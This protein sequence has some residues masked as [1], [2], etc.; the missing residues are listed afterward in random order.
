IL[1][2][3]KEELQMSHTA[4]P[5]IMRNRAK[6]VVK[7]IRV[8]MLSAVSLVL[9]STLAYSQAPLL[10]PTVTRAIDLI[11]TYPA[12]VP[13]GTDVVFKRKDSSSGRTIVQSGIQVRVFTLGDNE[14]RPKPI[15]TVADCDVYL[16]VVH[17]LQSIADLEL[18]FVKMD[19]GWVQLTN[20]QNSTKDGRWYLV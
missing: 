3:D 1:L 10:R 12:R 15:T 6:H 19:Q 8:F 17:R 7:P 9:S 14:S 18:R 2:T 16:S 13:I 11:Y 20:S 5:R 4:M